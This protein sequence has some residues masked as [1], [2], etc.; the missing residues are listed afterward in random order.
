[1]ARL[2]LQARSEDVPALLGGLG[3]ASPLESGAGR[4]DALLHWSGSLI[5]ASVTDLRGEFSVHVGKGRFLEVDPGLGRVFGLL[6]LR[7]LQRR[8]SL[9][10]SDLF[11]QGLAFDRIEGSFLLDA[12]SAYTTDSYLEGPAARIDIMGRTGLVD[13]DYD[14]YVTVT[15]HLSTG[16]PVAAALAGGPA[17]GAAVLV[18]QQLMGKQLEKIT[19][20]QYEVVGP[21]DDPTITRIDTR[22]K[23]SRT[24]DLLEGDH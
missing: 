7:A 1:M 22:P 4:A 20:Y 10:F 9:D 2:E 14:Q 19:R 12:G 21:W 5:P 24:P 11:A 15:P 6:S 13:Q 3:I 16:L 18:A 23:D 17:V 8:L